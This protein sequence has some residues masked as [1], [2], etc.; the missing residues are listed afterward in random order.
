[1]NKRLTWILV[2]ALLLVG[3]TA[4]L[5]SAPEAPANE[6]DH[7]SISFEVGAAESECAAFGTSVGKEFAYAFKID[8]WTDDVNGNMNGY[9]SAGPFGDGHTNS[10]TISN[11]GPLGFDW[12]SSPNG[13]GAVLVHSRQNYF[14]VWEYDP[15]VNGDTGLHAF[16]YFLEPPRFTKIAHVTFCWNP[17][18]SP[19]GDQWCSPG[20]WRQP[21]HLDSWAATGYSPDDLFF[22]A[23]NYYPQLSRPG[24]MQGATTNPT[25][26]QVLQAPQW[27]GGD[28][29]NAVGDLLSDAHPDVNFSG[30][31]VEDSC[32]LN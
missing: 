30:D 27:Y 1:M 19:P 12:S 25:L 20:Y 16:G 9:Y 2:L 28:A 21:H 15:R 3:A 10:I 32:P 26:W 24:Q 18:Y 22:D 6:P 4:A 5:A 31:R 14:H 17:D 23:L 7:K 11:S 8:D 29:F 13:I